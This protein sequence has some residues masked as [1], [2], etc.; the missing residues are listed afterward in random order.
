MQ[1]ELDAAALLVVPSR[2]HAERLRRW[3]EL[4]EGRLRVVHHGLSRALSRCPAPPFAADRPLRVLHLGHRSAVKGTGDLVEALVAL[5]AADR[6]RVELHLLGEEVEPG[7]DE[8]LRARA[9]GLELRSHG[10]Y[11][12]D[13]LCERVEALGGFHLAALPSRVHE[14]YGLV[15]D[16]ALALGIPTWVSERGA[17]R[18]RLGGAGQVL[19]AEDPA[20]WTAAFAA[21]LREPA[22]LAAQ[23][24][25]LPERI[26]AARDAALELEACYARLLDAGSC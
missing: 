4:D 21:L 20:A 23:R 5:E 1:A 24:A 25:A 22:R 19:P 9:G 6:A 18:E 12:L 7:F 13:E 15:L 14:S 10:G 26:P 16:E 17:P 2:A 11:A 8:G 3:I